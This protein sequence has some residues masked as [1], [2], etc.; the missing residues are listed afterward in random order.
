MNTLTD[1]LERLAELQKKS[2]EPL[3][4]L[5][6]DAFAVFERMARK[7]YE[8]MGDMVE[9]AVAQ[10]RGPLEHRAPRELYEHQMSEARAFA[11]RMSDR[12]AEYLALAEAMREAL[13]DQGARVTQSGGVARSEGSESIGAKGAS[14]DGAESGKSPV[15]TA[16]A[17]AEDR[18]ASP[19][20]ASRKVAAKKSTAKRSTV[21]ANAAKAKKVAA[22]KV[23]AKKVAAKDK[24][25]SAA[26]RAP[27][28][29]RA[30]SGSGSTSATKTRAKKRGGRRS[31]T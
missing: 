23:A 3:Q 1:R 11:E 12:A 2:L 29:K 14:S 6:G 16:A 30:S 17:S 4:G 5:G 19:G 18:D 10:S 26:K 8:L 28:R 24:K 27:A 25:T 22:K 21:K 20:R 31:A 9:Y 13:P 7:N 15:T